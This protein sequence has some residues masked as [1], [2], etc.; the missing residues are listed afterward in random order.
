ME[1][2]T[3]NVQIPHQ[4]LLISAYLAEP[5]TSDLEPK[6]AIIVVQ[7]IFGVNEHIQDVTRRF[8][9]KGYVAIAPAIYQRQAPDFAVGYSPEEFTLGRVHKNQ[10]KAEELLGDIQ[11]TIDYL[12]QLPQVQKTGV[13]AIGFC[14]GGHVTYLTATLE[15]IKA[16]ASFYGAGIPIWCPGHEDKATIDYTGDI[17]NKIHCFFGLEDE[18]IPPEHINQIES[19]LQKYQIDHQIHCYEGAEHGFFCDR[20][21]SYNQSSAQDAWIKVLELFNQTLH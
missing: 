12:Y 8:A 3:S 18:Y 1:I 19:K 13:G 6:P 11:A 9:Q 14:F 4:D 5:R 15:E 16:T 21:E 20:R 17:K 7:E 2:L 10:T